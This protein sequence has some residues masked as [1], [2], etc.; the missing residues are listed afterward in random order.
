MNGRR[1]RLIVLDLRLPQRD[2]WWLL[3]VLQHYEQLRSIPIVIISIE[4]AYEHQPKALAAGARAYIEK[5]RE[6]NLFFEDVREKCSP[7]LP[8]N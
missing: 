5:S 6:I 1:L 8:C 3:S 2:G 7:L 4:S